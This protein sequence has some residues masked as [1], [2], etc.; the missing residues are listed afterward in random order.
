M[1]K[2]PEAHSSP[3]VPAANRGLG[4]AEDT[5]VGR[6]AQTAAGIFTSPDDPAC[7]RWVEYWRESR[8]RSAQLLAQFEAAALLEITGRRVLD[9]GCGTGA[10]ASVLENRKV[11]HYTG[12]GTLAAVLE[13]QR[14]A[15]YVGLDYHRHVLQ[16][17]RPAPGRSFIQGSGP[18]LP[19]PDRS[20]DLI[21]AFD[22]IEHLV[23]GRPWQL[24]FLQE[25]KRVLAPL[26]MVLLT[27]PNFWYPYDAHS[28][29]W[30]PQFL[31]TFLADR[32]IA[33]RNPGFL[34]EHKSFANI[35]LLG[36]RALRRLI[37]E[38]GL[39]SLTELPCCLDRDE[40]RRLHPLYGW[41]PSWGLGWLLHAEFWPILVH[42]EERDR[43]RRKLR[44]FWSYEHAQ[45]AP[46]P[47]T[48]FAP[49][50]DF[51][52]GYFNPQLG[53]GWYW[54]ERESRAFRWIGGKA[55]CWLQTREPAFFLV[56]EGYAPWENRLR[57]FVDGWWVGEKR[58]PAGRSFEAA[59]LLPFPETAGRIFEVAIECSETRHPESAGDQRSLGVML[60]SVGL[61]PEVEA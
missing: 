51:E 38:A 12:P 61:Q 44:K 43:L 55:T 7:R 15:L 36:P 6:L 24:R 33:R 2:S 28:D 40:F 11:F 1:D 48:E 60:F 46:E 4:D 30:G 53:D 25:V 26:G 54:Y 39:A 56:V 19:F 13:D 18:H 52:R 10:L 37:E 49:V 3:D 59:Y 16:F 45:P 34:D 17:A 57:F 8:R 42:R 29:L 23:G 9:L 58:V 32:Y 20:F 21:C 14:P 22:V 41:L 35:P 27:T 31:P 47:V 5:E 50:I